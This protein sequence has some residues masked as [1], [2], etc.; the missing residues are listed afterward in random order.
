MNN[1]YNM[2]NNQMNRFNN[3]NYNNGPMRLMG[4]ARLK[5]EFQLCDQDDELMQIGCSFGL[6]DNNMFKWKVTMLGPKNTPYEGGVFTININFPEDYPNHG[7]EFKFVNKIYH[8]NVDPRRDLGHIS[9]STINDWRV[10]GKVYN[11]PTYNVKHALYDIFCLFY[12]QGIEDAYEE[13]MAYQ[14]RYNKE[15]FDKIAK[16]WTEK[17]AKVKKEYLL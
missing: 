1:I 5:K 13:D 12:N 8:L 10:R 16:E 7:P 4:L 14:Y 15:K 11:L 17:Y 9:L 3:Y 2:N 6:C